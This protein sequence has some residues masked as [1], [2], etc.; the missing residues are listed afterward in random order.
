MLRL[1]AQASVDELGADGAIVL[2]ID[3]RG[4]ALVAG[5]RGVDLSQEPSIDLDEVGPELGKKLIAAATEHFDH[6]HTIPLVSDGGLFGAIVLLFRG[7][8]ALDEERIVVAGGFADLAASMLHK[9]YQY[10]KLRRADAEVR[11]AHEVLL[12]TEKLRALGEMAAGISHD[13]KNILSP[14]KMQAQVLRQSPTKPELVLKMAQGIDR[15]ITRGVD[16]IERLRDFSR[17]SPEAS[18]AERSD[19][20]DLAREAVELVAHIE[21]TRAQICLEPGETHPVMVAQSELVSAIVNLVK[22]ALDALANEAGTIVV[23]T[24]SS[25]YGAWVQ[26]EDTGGGIPDEVRSR[27]FE[28]F[29]TTKGKSGTGL[30]LSMVYALVERYAGRIDVESTPGTGTTITLTFPR[31]PAEHDSLAPTAH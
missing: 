23:R 4:C 11:A 18:G 26:V 28:P 14:L 2:Q 8:A 5:R 16:M 9:V 7:E 19:L 22:N 21:H 6:A 10:E 1:I 24:G 31:A 13:L 15:V 3:E 20:N 27:L 29:F 30:G 25:T 12:R 17:Q